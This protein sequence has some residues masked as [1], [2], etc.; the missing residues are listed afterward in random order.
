[1]L[2]NNQHPPLEISPTD[3]RVWK[4]H[5]ITRAFVFP[6]R[7]IQNQTWIQR[8]TAGWGRSNSACLS[9]AL[10]KSSWSSSLRRGGLITRLIQHHTFFFSVSDTCLSTE[11]PNVSPRQTEQNAVPSDHTSEQDSVQLTFVYNRELW[12]WKIHARDTRRLTDRFSISSPRDFVFWF[13]CLRG[14]TVSDNWPW[15]WYEAKK[16]KN[17]KMKQIM[18]GK[19]CK[20]GGSERQQKS[21]NI[22][23]LGEFC[24]TVHP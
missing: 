23:A 18:S 9:S 12:L 14:V 13:F 8:Q 20:A 19:F 5:P 7:P 4:E 24:R 15:N 3:Q 11:L 6:F 17:F 10:A 16:K 21:C 22:Q 2:F 1:M